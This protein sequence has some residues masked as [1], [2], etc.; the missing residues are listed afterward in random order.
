VVKVLNYYTFDENFLN[1][2]FKAIK[3]AELE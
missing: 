2:I 1:I 3:K